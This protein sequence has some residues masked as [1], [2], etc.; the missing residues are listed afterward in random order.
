MGF[1]LKIPKLISMTLKKTD[2]TLQ[3]ELR[4]AR[5]R[6][7]KLEAVEDHRQKAEEALRK[8]KERYRAVVE[9][10]TELISRCLPD[11]T[12]TFVNSAYCRYF[13]K[14]RQELLGTNFFPNIPKSDRPFILKQF[15]SF[16]PSRPVATYEHQIIAAK[17]RLRW[18]QWSS[19]AIYSDSGKLLE[20]QSVGRDITERK[21]AELGLQASENELREQQKILK[22]K[23]LLLHELLDQIEIEKRQL[24][25]DV[26]ANVDEL[27]FP[28]LRKLRLPDGSIDDKYFTLLQHSLEGLASSFGRKISQPS[29]KLSPREVEI[30][31]MVK[32][33]LTSKEIAGLLK[34]AFKTVEIHRH[35]IRRKLNIANKPVNLNTFLHS[36]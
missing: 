15:S 17:G 31:N 34:I 24:K 2:T 29:L 7:K 8:S 26:T 10:Q 1:S 35:H 33:G 11:Y 9:D 3:R 21:T 6:I 27:L 22:K 19:R 25:E 14:S 32:N 28:L 12:L 4:S 16:S 18:Q 20:I 13:G 36:L 23:N 30:A 5:A